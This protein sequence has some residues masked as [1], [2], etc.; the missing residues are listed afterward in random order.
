MNRRLTLQVAIALMFLIAVPLSLTFAQTLEPD[1]VTETVE[2]VREL[3]EQGDE[4]AV[5]DESEEAERGVVR[6]R[7]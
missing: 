6:G 5:Q 7:R 3:A 4:G 1:D 2:L